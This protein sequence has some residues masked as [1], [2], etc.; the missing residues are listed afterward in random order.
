MNGQFHLLSELDSTNGNPVN[1]TLAIQL[2]SAD[3]YQYRVLFLHEERHENEWRFA[4]LQPTV[5]SP[6]V[7]LT[8]LNSIVDAGL[9]ASSHATY[10]IPCIALKSA[11]STARRMLH[12]QVSNCLTLAFSTP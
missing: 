3:L 10:W 12:M 8:E 9:D 5:V 11:L 7:T 2:V 1:E 6:T 4:R